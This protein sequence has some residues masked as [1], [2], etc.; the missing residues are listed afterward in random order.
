MLPIPHSL[1]SELEIQARRQEHNGKMHLRRVIE[2]TPMGLGEGPRSYGV[3][4]DVTQIE[5]RT[6]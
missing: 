1:A 5:E 2:R 3:V 4:Q 6:H